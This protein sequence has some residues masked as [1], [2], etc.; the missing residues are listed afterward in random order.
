MKLRHSLLAVACVLGLACS[1]RA[2]SF[3]VNLGASAQNFVE[4]GIGDNGA[5]YAQWFLT[6]G[7]CS[8]SGGN[9]VC[10][11]SGSYTG[12]QPGYT[13]GTYSLVTSYVG[14]GPTFS[15]PWGPGPSPLVGISIAPG[16]GYFEF[17]YLAPGS[18]ITLDLNESGGPDYVFP[19]WNGSTF[20]NGFTISPAETA[21]CTGISTCDPYDVGETPGATWSATEVGVGYLSTSTATPE[22]SSLLLL[23]TG[24]L[25]L[26][27][28]LRRKL[29][30]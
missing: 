27:G 17:E 1:A 2:T 19:I 23:S 4:T 12:S 13:S 22:P 11:M 28:L 20:V 21:T 25:G 24:V 26:G 3:T 18:L 14:T 30:L 29:A 7:A 16:S 15:T 9:T 5:G 6:F 8:P 10:T